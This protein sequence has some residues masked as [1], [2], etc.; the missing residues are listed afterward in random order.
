MSNALEGPL[1]GTGLGIDSIKQAAVD[2]GEEIAKM[3]TTIF[4]VLGLFSVV[5]GLLLI[6][7]I[8]SMLAAERRMEI[9]R[10]VGTRSSQLTK[11]FIAE[12]AGMH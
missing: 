2:D 8:F 5:S 6:V 10:A 11:Q 3:F 7:L 9:S 4:L 12:G 1:A